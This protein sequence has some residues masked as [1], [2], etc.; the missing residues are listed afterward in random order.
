MFESYAYNLIEEWKT[1]VEELDLQA[2][3]A[4]RLERIASSSLESVVKELETSNGLLKKSESELLSLKEEV[5]LLEMS[6]VRQRASSSLESVVKELETSNGLLKKSEFEL[7]SLK[8]EVGLLEMSNVRQRGDLEESEHAL[9]KIK[10]EAS[11]MTKKAV[12]L[13][14]ELDTVKEEKP[15]ALNNEKL[16]TSSV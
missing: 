3:E 4:K 13:K 9:K 1:K 8:E 11:K 7:F 16:A 15:T 5:S 10:E 6:N 14:T 2:K 12:V